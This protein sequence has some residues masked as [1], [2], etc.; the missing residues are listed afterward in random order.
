MRVNAIHPNLT[1][2]P[3]CSG[4]VCKGDT[5]PPNSHNL[6]VDDSYTG[7]PRGNLLS[8]NP[9]RYSDGHGN[10][11]LGPIVPGLLKATSTC[12]NLEPQGISRV[13]HSPDTRPE[14]PPEAGT[15]GGKRRG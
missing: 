6:H 14:S 12:Q 1:D 8:E 10:C 3:P 9:P 5:A 15:S 11:T 4:P 7:P 13:F 2:E